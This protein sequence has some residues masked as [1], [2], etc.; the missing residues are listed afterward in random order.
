M[1]TFSAFILLIISAGVWALAGP[2]KVEI[3]HVPDGGI[4]PQ[5][6]IDGKGILHLVYY[7]G[8]ATAGDMFYVRQ[9]PGSEQFSA[10]IKVNSVPGSAIATGTIRSEQIALG[11]NGRLHVAW[12]PSPKSSVKGMQYARLSDAGDAFEDQKTVT[13]EHFGLDGGG[14]LAADDSGNVYVV[15]H[16]PEMEKGDEGNRRVWVARSIDDG[17]TFAPESAASNPNTGA[18]GCCGLKA[19]AD[20]RSG[21]LF[22]L[23]R[24]ARDNEMLQRVHRDMVMLVSADH[25]KT[26]STQMLSKMT[27]NACIMS[28]ESLVEGATGPVGAWESSPG[29]VSWGEI[30]PQALSMGRILEAPATNGNK[31]KH[32]AIAQN[33]D[34]FV[35]LAW[36]EGVEWGKGG[37][38]AWQVLRGAGR[39]NVYARGLEKG[40]PVWSRPAA[41]TRGDGTFV[42]I[43]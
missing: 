6:M 38:I 26:F 21:N 2:P 4:Q 29:H 34:G 19:F 28:S 7:K 18:C 24:T 30:E 13:S 22:I 9:E 36:A 43:Y 42:V 5:A 17:K 14:S 10:P 11:R 25:A 12:N 40:L 20:A 31:R 23:F 3:F 15:W 39:Q 37:D 27:L 1:R 33:H 32:P 41:V 8:D 35:L 16:A